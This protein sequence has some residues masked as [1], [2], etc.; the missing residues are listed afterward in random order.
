MDFFLE[1][2]KLSLLGHSDKNNA[3]LFIIEAAHETRTS[4]FSVCESSNAH[5]KVPIG[6]TDRRFVPEA[7]SM[8][9]LNVC[10]QQRLWQDCAYAQ[11]C[12][13]LCRSPI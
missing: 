3:F 7:S 11:A 2:T 5:A 10:E 6:A 9:L 8:S 4:C 12:L 13:S 1:C